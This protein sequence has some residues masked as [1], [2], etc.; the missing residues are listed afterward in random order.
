M[1]EPLL[2]LLHSEYNKL[3]GGDLRAPFPICNAFAC[4]TIALRRWDEGKS[5]T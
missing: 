3:A 5:S 1:N 2:T 4:Y